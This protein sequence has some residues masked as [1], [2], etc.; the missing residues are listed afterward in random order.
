MFISFLFFPLQ[1]LKLPIRFLLVVEVFSMCSRTNLHI[2]V[3]LLVYFLVLEYEQCYL[4]FKYLRLC[5]KEIELWVK[6]SQIR[7]SAISHTLKLW[8]MDRSEI[9]LYYVEHFRCLCLGLLFGLCKVIFFFVVNSK[10][11][12]RTD[13]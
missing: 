4:L 6:L 10:T 7:L 2:L 13:D 12:I 9:E 5:F 3:V 8:D 1:S 11:C